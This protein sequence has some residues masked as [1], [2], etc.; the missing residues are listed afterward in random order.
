[1]K[2]FRLLK[3]ADL[4]LIGALLLVIGAL[5]FVLRGGEDPGETV[6]VEIGG[7]TVDAFPLA[8][9]TERRYETGSGG[10]NVVKVENGAVSVLEANCPGQAC[11]R[12]RAI[13][14]AGES[15]I[16]LPHR[17][18]VS[19]SGEPAENGVDAVA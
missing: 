16:C 2:E 11:V 1:M 17:L 10:V 8:E 12:H 4:I 7:E 14:R 13:S 18:V 5:L 9:D 19:V 6:R 3:K 15:I